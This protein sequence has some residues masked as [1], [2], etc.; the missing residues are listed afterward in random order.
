MNSALFVM[1]DRQ[2]KQ[3]L[4]NRQRLIVSMVQPLLF[5]IAFGFGLGS[6]FAKAGNGNYIQYLIPGI[7]GMTVLMSS[8]MNGMSLIWDKQFG[9]LK[10]TL[11]A[12]VSR[13]ALLFGRCLGGATTSTLQGVIVLLLGFFMGFRITNWYLFPLAIIFMFLIALL[14]N[15]LGT[16]VACRFDDMHSFPTMM[17]FVVMPMVFISGLLFPIDNFPKVLQIIVKIN[18]F[19]YCID[20][21]RFSLGVATTFNVI[22]SIFIIGSLIVLTGFIGTWLFNKMET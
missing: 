15:L 19:T 2:V 8:A 18:P 17:N 22:L 4:R 16:S 13:T 3:Y 5:L 20:L 14:F 11:V 6:M 12:P 1:W 7:I 21:L 9:F 10:E